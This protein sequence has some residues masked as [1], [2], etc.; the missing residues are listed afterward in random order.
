FKE[1]I[2]HNL[3]VQPHGQ[4]TLV[5]APDVRL[6]YSLMDIIRGNIH[7]DEVTLSGPTVA[8]V[9]NPDGTT[10]LDPL[11]KSQ[12]EKPEK[13]PEK[14]ASKPSKPAQIDVRKVA[15]TDAT[16]RKVKV[17]KN[18]NRDVTELSHVN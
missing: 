10:N 16:I 7:V 12:K 6:R 17:Y 15:L 3:K 5:T 2:L 11:T 8:L 14:K 4:E 13:P 9:E 18:G 1:V